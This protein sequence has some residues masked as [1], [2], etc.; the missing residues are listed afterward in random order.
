M[1]PAVNAVAWT[2]DKLDREIELQ[3]VSFEEIHEKLTSD[4][5][6]L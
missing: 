5:E 4:A 6:L 3:R 1:I 2:L